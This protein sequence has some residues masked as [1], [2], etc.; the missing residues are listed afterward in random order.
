VS[1]P[2]PEQSRRHHF[3]LLLKERGKAETKTKETNKQKRRR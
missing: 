3:V 2:P 1:E